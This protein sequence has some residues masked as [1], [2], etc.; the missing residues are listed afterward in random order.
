MAIMIPNTFEYPTGFAHQWQIGFQD[1][2]SPIMEGIVYLHDDLMALL[3]GILLFVFW[4]LIRTVTLSRQLYVKA[5]ESNIVYPRTLDSHSRNATLLEVVWTLAPSAIL[6]VLAIP[7]FA[8]LYAIDEVVDPII[9]LKA[10]GHQWYWSYE[11]SDYATDINFDSYM[12]PEEDL[13]LGDLR[14]LEVDNRVILPA[15]THVRV[16]VTA[17]DV[18]HSWSIP[19]LGVKMDACP[20]RLNQVGLFA[21]H[22]G[23]YYGQCSEICG[24]NHGFMP[25]CVEIV[26]LNQYLEYLTHV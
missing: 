2:A 13:Q 20:G 24:V 6:L 10:I 16:I 1:I 21:V 18:L 3:I 17:T 22:P 25:I 11:C 14:L 4:I 5:N 8:L 23:I 26:N 12:V 19:S 9:T 15:S 7:S